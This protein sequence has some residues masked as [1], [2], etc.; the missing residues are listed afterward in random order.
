MYVLTWS[1]IHML[2]AKPDHLE[3][4]TLAA[5]QFCLRNFSQQKF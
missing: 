1:H 4:V 5:F 3:V 2:L